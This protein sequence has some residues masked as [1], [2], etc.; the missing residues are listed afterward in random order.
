MLQGGERRLFGR[1]AYMG[2]GYG[3]GTGE[4]ASRVPRHAPCLKLP[5]CSL[6]PAARREARRRRRNGP[7]TSGAHAR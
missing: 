4:R 5:Q 7:I 6:R 1:V 3:D 2:T